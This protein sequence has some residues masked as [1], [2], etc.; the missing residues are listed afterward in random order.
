MKIS[1]ACKQ[2][3]LKLMKSHDSLLTHSAATDAEA[4]EAISKSLVESLRNPTYR[5]RIGAYVR[6]SYLSGLATH[7]VNFNNQLLQALTQPFLRAFK[8]EFREAEAMMKGMAEGFMEAFP[9]F[10]TAVKTRPIDFD[11]A[12]QTAFDIVPNKTADAI[13]SFPTRLTGA[14][15]EGFSAVLERMEFN[16]MRHRIANKFPDEFF[17]RQNMSKEE[18][19]KKLEDIALGNTKSN[20][21][22]MNQLADLSP[23]LHQQLTEFKMFNVFRSRLGNAA[24]DRLGNAMIKTKDAVPELNLII[25]FITTPINVVKEAGGYIPGL[26]IL[27]ERRA[28]LD[29]PELQARLSVALDK[30]TKAVS[31][32]TQ[33]RFLEKADRLRGE[34]EFKKSKIADF[35]TQQILGAGLM[36]S[37]YSMYNAGVITGHP[38]N[39]PAERQR[40]IT[41]GIP[42]MSVKIGNNWISYARLEP[43]ATLMGLTVD[44]MQELREKRVKGDD[45][46]I[47]DFVKVVGRNLTDKTFTEGLSKLFL[48]MQEPDR[49]AESFLVSMTNPV[50][51]ALSAQIAKL[52]DDVKR[53]IRDPELS[54]WILNNM[55]SRI[56]GLRETLPAQVNI[57]G[58]E[59]KL[60]T[61]GGTLTGI[62]VTPAERENINKMFD[63]PYLRVARTSR[64]VGGIELTGEQY[65]QM[66]ADINR[67]NY[68]MLNPL[69]NNPGF[70]AMPRPLQAKFVKSIIEQNRQ[71]IRLMTLGKLV[72]DPAQRATYIARELSKKGLQ[73][74]IGD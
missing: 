25:P 49:Y 8:G 70:T 39:D 41:A 69:A 3:L 9:R 37:A 32:E 60:G 15:D 30:A 74:D 7:V 13:L 52:E 16:A 62:E 61:V 40:Q 58:Q 68:M 50:I 65:S 71:Q 35:R 18:F 57:V 46:S 12:K 55:K 43:V 56:P 24:I 64:K 6:N 51:P 29:I 10:M 48:A 27:R 36:M 22:W 19:I 5:E 26:G 1:D 72:Q 21:P 47:A 34:I 31:P 73:E 44:M 14:L 33:A 20:Q 11:R 53:E 42:P 63:N 38:S 23:E 45:P 67:M 54:K 17:R 66:E 2:Y 4:L 59:Q 28:K